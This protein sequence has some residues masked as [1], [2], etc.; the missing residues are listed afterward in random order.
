MS[1]SS[2]CKSKQDKKSESMST[3]KSKTAL[4]RHRESILLPVR[5]SCIEIFNEEYRDLLSRDPPSA[6][7]EVV[8]KR[9]VVSYIKNVT[10]LVADGPDDIDEIIT[11]SNKY[12]VFGV[13]ASK[14]RSIS[15]AVYTITTGTMNLDIKS[16]KRSAVFTHFHFIDMA[17]GEKQIHFETKGRF[18]V[19]GGKI[20]LPLSTLTNTFSAADNNYFTRIQFKKSTVMKI[21]GG[22]IG[23]RTEKLCSS[24]MEEIP[25]SNNDTTSRK[26][27]KVYN[28]T[29][30]SK[31]RY[32]LDK[33]E[34]LICRYKKEI[35]YLEKELKAY[36]DK[37][38]IDPHEE[39]SRLQAE[40]AAISKKVYQLQIMLCEASSEQ[41]D[42]FAKNQLEMKRYLNNLHQLKEK[43]CYQETL[44]KAYIGEK[45]K[46]SCA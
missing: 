25:S 16:R 44:I 37:E 30:R 9:D 27:K 12:R 10:T 20:N 28:K 26:K 5:V 36:D 15:H 14:S 40:L 45:Y 31:K 1:K 46:V 39:Y 33:K 21:L 7:L 29:H 8:E 4:L 35:E 18:P 13:T 43:Y 41:K 19:E 22:S 32:K 3:D 24:I 42:V 38:L 23:C 6:R 11:L 2:E 34:A 17:G